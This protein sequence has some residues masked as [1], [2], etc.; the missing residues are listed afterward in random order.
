MSHVDLWLALV[1][2]AARRELPL[3]PGR[4]AWVH[5]ARGAVEV[6]GARL[7]EGDGAA[8]SGAAAVTLADGDSAEVLLFD[9]A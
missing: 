1:E 3:R 2:T 8:L 7:A 5:V 4:H 9:L 6:N